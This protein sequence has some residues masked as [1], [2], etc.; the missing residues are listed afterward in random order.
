[1][2]VTAEEIKQHCWRCRFTCHLH[3]LTHRYRNYKAVSPDGEE[4]I[5]VVT[6]AL[7]FPWAPWTCW[8]NLDGNWEKHTPET[9][10]DR[11]MEILR[12]DSLWERESSAAFTAT[13]GQSGLGSARSA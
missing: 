9:F 8:I 4:V 10:G 2:I 3:H 6:Y 5:S 13:S 12:R 11:M 7:R 1:M